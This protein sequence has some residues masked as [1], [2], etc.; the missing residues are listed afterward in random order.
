MRRNNPNIFT[1]RFF[2]MY[3]FRIIWL[4]PAAAGS[5]HAAMLPPPLEPRKRGTRADRSGNV[6]DVLGF[7]R[8]NGPASQASIAR[9]TGLSRATVNHIVQSLRD[10]GT[11][12]YEWKN[13]REAH[14]CLAST[15]GCVVTLT[16]SESAIKAVLF[17]FDAKQRT[18]LVS[19]QV[20]EHAD[21]APSPAMALD[22][23]NRLASIARQRSA[24]VVGMAVAIVGPID[25]ASGAIAPWAWQR[26]PHWK[27][28]DIHKHFTRHL[29][30]PVAVDNDANFAALAEWS[31]GA[32]RGCS[33]FLSITCSEGIGGGFVINGGIYHGGTGLA[34]EIGHMVIED[35]GDLCFCGSRGCLTSLATERAI[36][37]A[38]PDQGAPKASLAE[39]I[40]SAR[41]GD[42]ACQRVLSETGLHLGRALATVV[43]VIGPGVIA[44]GGTLGRAGDIVLGGLR[45]S[46]E[47][48]NLSAI[49][50]GTRFCIAEILDDAV[51]L[52]A[53]ASVL[54]QIDTGMNAL[55][56][57][58]TTPG[59]MAA[60]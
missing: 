44:I 35:A 47:V 51:E 54:S 1:A 24:Q 42:A 18:D 6:Q 10:Q 41:L 34:G 60:T 43:R 39:V 12:Q 11:V 46:A 26:L 16:V 25:R 36:L 13:K 31:W 33:D 30:I 58:M 15:Q 40:E 38:L 9:A 23:F 56:P 50:G 52:G 57:W 14:V 2:H 59:P 19:A 17:D 22:M 20:P 45:A 5:H 48:I 4:D 29:R 27:Q 32:G 53:L 8:G 3:D 21:A 55:S 49:G 37:K 28:V 7:L